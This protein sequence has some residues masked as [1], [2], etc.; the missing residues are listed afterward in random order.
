[1]RPNFGTAQ[2]GRIRLGQKKTDLGGGIDCRTHEGPRWRSPRLLLGAGHRHEHPRQV[3]HCVLW[4]GGGA[5]RAEHVPV[6]RAACS[7]NLPYQESK[8][9]KLGDFPVSGGNC[10]SKMRIG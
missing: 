6:I 5:S 7:E 10:A 8:A 9:G 1:M 2:P 4:Q 3:V